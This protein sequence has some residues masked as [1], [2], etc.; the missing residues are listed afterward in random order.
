MNTFTCIFTILSLTAVL[1]SSVQAAAKT[2]E[3]IDTQKGVYTLLPLPY[4][5]SGLEPSIDTRTVEIHYSK[6]HQSYVDNLNQAIAGTPWAEK[7]MQDLFKNASTVPVKIK[8][9]AGGHWNHTFYWECMT[10]DPLRRKMSPRLEKA[11]VE[12]FGSVD[13]FKE[14][15]RN[16]GLERFGSGYV[17]L[18]DNNGS[19]S[20]GSTANQDNP[21]MQGVELQGRPLLVSDVWEH[22][23][24]LLYQNKRAD[25]LNNFWSVVDWTKVEER[26]FNK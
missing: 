10:S 12:V 13:Q 19:L 23:Y 20:I 1:P 18:V 24:Y 22:S 5:Y 8:N 15:F 26:L 2:S 4:S 16:A 6:H 9:N 21:L 25:Y 17:W 14:R 7:T 3:N 11:L